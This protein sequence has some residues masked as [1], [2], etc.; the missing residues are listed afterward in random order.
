MLAIVLGGKGE[1]C[2]DRRKLACR[3][4][5][6]EALGTPESEKGAKVA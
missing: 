6:P 3:G 2:P 5:R 4:R 1:E